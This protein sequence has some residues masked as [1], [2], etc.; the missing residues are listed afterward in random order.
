MALVERAQTPSP[1]KMRPLPTLLASLVTSALFIVGVALIAHATADGTV[2]HRPWIEGDPPDAGFA[3][4]VVVDAGP[5][6]EPDAGVMITVSIDAGV[7]LS[8][9]LPP[10]VDGPPF[11]A[12]EVAAAAVVVVERCAVEALRWDPSLGGPFSL[13]VDLPVGTPPAI[14][15]EGL[16]SPVL[17]S[18]VERRTPE[19]SLPPAFQ[20]AALEVP[21]GVTARA[22]LDAT[23]RVTWSDAVVVSGRR[24]HEQAK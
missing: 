19:M 3:V 23:G 9:A 20:A 21:L 15:V 2:M 8:P 16:T 10:T 14:V 11:S 4:V 7:D 17:S 18:C 1:F 5:P 6:E 22:T 24:A 13:F 12:S